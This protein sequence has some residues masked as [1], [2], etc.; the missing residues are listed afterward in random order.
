MSNDDTLIS[1]LISETY[2]E[3]SDDDQPDALADLRDY[4]E[5]K[6]NEVEF[7]SMSEY[8]SQ[9]NLTMSNLKLIK[10]TQ[11]YRLIH[12]ESVI[13]FPSNWS[14]F[15]N[16]KNNDIVYLD[17]SLDQDYLLDIFSEITGQCF[18]LALVQDDKTVM[19]IYLPEVSS[20]EHVQW[21]RCYFEKKNQ[22]KV[23]E[24]AA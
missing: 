24:E 21:L 22:E 11:C 16:I 23:R 14:I 3:A 13:D 6:I 12:D 18:N 9:N 5:R 1:K 19:M 2:L 10:R 17:Q 4:Y 7:F 20:K 15:K 8:L